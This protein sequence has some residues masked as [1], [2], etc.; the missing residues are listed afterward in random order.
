MRS[1]S[2]SP[3]ATELPAWLTS[4]RRTVVPAVR[5]DET[6]SAGDAEVG[7]TEVVR[8]RGELAVLQARLVAT[9]AMSAG[10]DTGAALTRGMG[11]SR[12]EARDAVKVAGWWPAWRGWPRHSRRARP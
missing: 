2:S 1:M 8:L 9:V 6:I 10:R 12:R 4:L 11:L 5:A 7:L 3:H